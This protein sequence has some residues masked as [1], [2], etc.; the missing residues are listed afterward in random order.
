M[1][2]HKNVAVKY[3]WYQCSFFSVSIKNSTKKCGKGLYADKE[4]V[5]VSPAYLTKKIVFLIRIH[6]NIFIKDINTEI[7]SY[8]DYFKEGLSDVS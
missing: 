5:I 2:T 1:V 3:P 6:L 4:E 7:W 8:N